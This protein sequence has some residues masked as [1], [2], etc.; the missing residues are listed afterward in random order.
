MLLCFSLSSPIVH[1]SELVNDRG[2]KQVRKGEEGDERCHSAQMLLQSES[3]PQF[4]VFTVSCG[5]HHEQTPDD[6]GKRKQS[7]IQSH[8]PLFLFLCHNV[9][10]DTHF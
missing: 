9:H 5:W 10:A 2:V 4:R 6:E 1:T 7:G 8:L 3:F